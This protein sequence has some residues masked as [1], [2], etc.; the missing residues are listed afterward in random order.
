MLPIFNTHARNSLSFALAT[1][2]IM[3]L[4]ITKSEN[5]KHVLHKLRTPA[6]RRP[7]SDIVKLA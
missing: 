3:L 5:D 2:G 4:D 1:K 7:I 6:N